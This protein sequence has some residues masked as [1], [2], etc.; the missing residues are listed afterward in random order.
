MHW[1]DSVFT[2]TLSCYIHNVEVLRNNMGDI[3]PS[4]RP[5]SLVA[6]DNFIP[7]EYCKAMFVR[8]N[9]WKHVKSCPFKPNSQAA[10]ADGHHQG[11]GSLLMPVTG[12]REIYWVL[13][14]K[15]RY[16]RWLSRDSTKR[17]YWLQHFCLMN[18]FQHV[19]KLQLLQRTCMQ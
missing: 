19:G 4:E 10:A 18:I 13:C 17:C 5:S 12:S 9:L 6:H 15:M 2:W 8:S 14:I 11:R 16:G 3:I 1:T 7:C